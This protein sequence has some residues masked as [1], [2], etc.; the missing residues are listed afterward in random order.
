MNAPIS[1]DLLARILR[2]YELHPLGDH[3]IP[4]WARVLENGR[5]L[6][7]ITG[8]DPHVVSL[9]AVFHDSR[10]ENEYQDEGHGTRGGA[11]ARQFAAE[12]LIKVTSGQLE[13][14]VRAC[15]L[16]TGGRPP[17]DITQLT[18]WDSDRLDLPR[19]GIRINPKYLCTDAARDVDVI[20]LCHRRSVE[21]HTPEWFNE[22]TQVIDR[23]MEE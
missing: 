21:Q 14:L 20:H 5:R 18:C 7:P 19:V 16:H 4:H 3:G 15:E 6:A 10:R 9:F 13:C 2:D 8:A 11:L 1:G 17:A 23:L 12:G 22:W